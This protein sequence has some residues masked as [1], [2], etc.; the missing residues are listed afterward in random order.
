MAPKPQPLDFLSRLPKHTETAEGGGF[1][2]KSFRGYPVEAAYMMH[3]MAKAET[4][5]AN[6][7]MDARYT[8]N[9]WVKF[10]VDE[11]LDSETGWDPADHDSTFEYTWKLGGKSLQ[12]FYATNDGQPAG[13]DTDE[14][15]KPAP[16]TM[17]M[18][19]IFAKGRVDGGGVVSFDGDP[20]T[21][22]G[23]WFLARPGIP[24]NKTK[25]E[26]K[27]SY[28]MHMLESAPA[29]EAVRPDLVTTYAD[30]KGKEFRIFNID[31]P[32][33][34]GLPSFALYWVGLSGVWDTKVVTLDNL[35]DDKGNPVKQQ[36]LFISQ[37][38][39]KLELE[40]GA[41]ATT[42]AE[43]TP[44]PAATKATTSKPTAATS[45]TKAAAKPAAAK[46]SSTSSSSDDA[47]DSLTEHVTR[48]ILASLPDKGKD[49]LH[50][51]LARAVVV[52]SGEFKPGTA[53][54]RNAN[55]AL[56]DVLESTPSREDADLSVELGDTPPLF[57]Y[58]KSTLKVSR[59]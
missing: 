25:L 47:P 42:T 3:R 26:P 7:D 51:L 6:P 30:K 17:E 21:L 8:L 23:R 32:A 28:Y 35:K 22:K 55:Q 44:A 13:I 49:I 27:S 59:Y 57:V 48:L 37:F 2:P 50:N 31:I 11:V 5:K 40:G 20:E 16:I 18:L 56:K 33:A 24:E 1:G 53:E 9:L 12:W 41:E 54:I 19:D 34:D 36:F 52:E 15:G 4:L 38:D 29:I 10:H 58:D 45:T 14:K 46:S 39:E 43:S